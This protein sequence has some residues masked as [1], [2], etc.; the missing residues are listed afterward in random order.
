MAAE[1]NGILTLQELQSAPALKR[2][3]LDID[4]LYQAYVCS[5]G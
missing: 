3:T 5:A 4:K 2:F 1:Q